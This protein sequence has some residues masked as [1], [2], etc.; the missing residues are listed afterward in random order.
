VSSPRRAICAASICAASICAV[1][2]ARSVL[3]QWVLDACTPY[4]G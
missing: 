3:R 1:G 4:K 2:T